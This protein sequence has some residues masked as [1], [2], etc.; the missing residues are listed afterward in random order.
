MTFSIRKS[1]ID[2]F[3]SIWS[4]LKQLFIK[5]KISKTK[6]QKLYLNSLNNTESIEL[7]LELK[8]KIIG[9]AAI[10]FRSDIQVQGQIGYLS[11]LIINEP[12]RGKGY[13]TKFLKDIFSILKKLKCKELHFPSTFKR[14][15]AHKFYEKLRFNKTAYF[16][17]KKI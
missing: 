2:D 1:T 8:N 3:S 4:L 17:W 15:K 10:K 16:F 14:K 6:T 13:G 11:E 7:V 12:Y 9:Y 5:D